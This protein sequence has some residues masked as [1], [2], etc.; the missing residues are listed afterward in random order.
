MQIL[1]HFWNKKGDDYDKLKRESIFWNNN[2]FEY[3][4]NGDRNNL[5]LEEYFNKIR[6]YLRDKIIDL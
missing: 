3:E 6:P 4:G 2:C 1:R 5:S